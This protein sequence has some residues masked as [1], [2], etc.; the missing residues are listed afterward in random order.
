MDYQHSKA[1][2]IFASCPLSLCAVSCTVQVVGKATAG[3]IFGEIGVFCFRPQP[4]TARTAELCQILRLSRTSLMNTIQANSEDGHI[5]MRNLFKVYILLHIFLGRKR[6]SLCFNAIINIFPTTLQKLQGSES[7][8]TGYQNRDPSWI[9]QEWFKGGPEERCCSEGGCQNYSHEDSSVHETGNISSKKPEA[10]EKSKTDMAHN[11]NK[12]AADVNSTVEDGQMSLHAAVRKG[13]IEMV[14]ILL[15]GGACTNKP[16]DRGWT[17]KAL[18]EQQGNK[19]I[20]DVLLSYENR[21]KVDEHRIDFTEPET[22]NDAKISQQKH[23]EISGST[24][25]NF[26][27]KM[28]PPEPSSHIYSCPNNKEA[29]P[30]TKKRVTI[31]MQLHS[32]MLQKPQGWLIILPDSIEELLRIGGKLHLLS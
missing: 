30:I 11:F 25:F 19:S 13:H 7:T 4:F 28:L 31:H 32:S 17:P 8:G 24:C 21:M 3:D 5:I 1:Y 16:D 10:T 9:H 26:H 14:K 18:A 15:E 22:T 20:Y 2:F 12:Q 23:K 29:K 27:S 6:F